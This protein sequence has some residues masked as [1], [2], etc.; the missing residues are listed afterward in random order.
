M[1]H[2]GSR[3]L[4]P[5][6]LLTPEKEKYLK[7]RLEAELTLLNNLIERAKSKEGCSP[8]STNSIKG[9]RKIVMRCKEELGLPLDGIPGAEFE[10][11][12]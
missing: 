5:R 4:K 8:C 2:R 1:R 12:I 9:L 7:G 11:P 6:G 3:N 10:N